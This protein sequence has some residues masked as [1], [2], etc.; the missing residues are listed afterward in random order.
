MAH[1]RSVRVVA[2][3]MAAVFAFFG[4]MKFIGGELV[5]AQF[6]AWGYPGWF[7]YVTGALEIAAAVL[8]AFGAMRFYGAVLGAVV[9]VGAAITHLKEPEIGLLPIGIPLLVGCLWVAMHLRPDWLRRRAAA[10][11]SP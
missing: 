10:P 1:P 3:V 2:S 8:L 7:A 5:Q 11:G 4:A 9:M 6:A